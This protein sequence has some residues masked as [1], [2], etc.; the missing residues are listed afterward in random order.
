MKLKLKLNL[1]FI[2]ILLVIIIIL[3]IFISNNNLEKFIVVK[4]TDNNK[5]TDAISLPIPE[6]SQVCTGN[7]CTDIL[8][9]KDCNSASYYFDSDCVRRR[10][11][12]FHEGK[13]VSGRDCHLQNYDSGCCEGQGGN[14]CNCDDTGNTVEKDCN[15][16]CGGT[17]VI[18]QC[19]VCGGDSSSCMGT[20]SQEANA[21]VGVICTSNSDCYSGICT[22]KTGEEWPYIKGKTCDGRPFGSPC[23]DYAKHCIYGHQC[24]SNTCGPINFGYKCDGINDD[25]CQGGYY[26]KL[27]GSVG[28]GYYCADDPFQDALYKK[29]P[30]RR[31]PPTAT[32]F[33]D[34]KCSEDSECYSGICNNTCQGRPNGDYCI[35][36]SRH[37]QKG[38]QCK[39]SSCGLIILA[40]GDKCNDLNDDRCSRR[41]SCQYDIL[42]K[43]YI[44]NPDPLEITYI[45]D[46]GKNPIDKNSENCNTKSY[47]NRFSC[48]DI[49]NIYN[50]ADSI[51]KKEDDTYNTMKNKL[52]DDEYTI[53]K[54]RLEGYGYI[55]RCRE[56]CNIE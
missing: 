30:F 6:I 42:T 36:S 48:R 50:T 32:K 43:D 55:D 54:N 15:D 11:Y 22:Y 35:D 3:I 19:G 47:N 34:D 17:S 9:H 13:T 16:V 18:D 2:S 26:C 24:R 5:I 8:W 4:N 10:T 38:H 28:S 49:L 45:R 33:I 23:T 20:S 53:I 52:T 46:Y 12:I 1:T 27:R 37:C 25:R 41:N 29:F 40:Q 44:C 56:V 39:Y 7:D 31:D 14:G 51:L 21:N